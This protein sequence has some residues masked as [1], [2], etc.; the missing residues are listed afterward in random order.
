MERSDEWVD[1]HPFLHLDLWQGICG[2]N[3]ESLQSQVYK[4][5]GAY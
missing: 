5:P 2:T 3:P 1:V 4:V